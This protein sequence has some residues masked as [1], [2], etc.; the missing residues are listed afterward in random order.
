MNEI[1]C[2][3][4]TKESDGTVVRTYGP[5]SSD[6]LIDVDEYDLPVH[7]DMVDV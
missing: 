7:V 4:Y 2:E 1:L 3:Y 5:I 6:L